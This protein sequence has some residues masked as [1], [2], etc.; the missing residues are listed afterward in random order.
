MKVV[1]RRNGGDFEVLEEKEIPNEVYFDLNEYCEENFDC[2]VLICTN[3]G[4][5]PANMYKE[6]ERNERY[7]K[8][9]WKERV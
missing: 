1:I 3:M 8:K 4:V 9:N 2:K 5:F 6:G 7:F